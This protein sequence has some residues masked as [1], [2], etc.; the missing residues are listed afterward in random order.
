M[1]RLA[2]VTVRTV[3]HYH[4]LG[5]LAEPERQENGYRS[6]DMRD[7]IRVLRI[8]NLSAAGVP[9]DETAI[10]LDGGGIADDTEKLLE[11]LDQELARKIEYL[12]SQRALIASAR[13]LRTA[14]DLPPTL[15]HIIAL[16]GST[17]ASGLAASTRD[18][19]V[20]LAHLVGVDD[21][22]KVMAFFDRVSDPRILP[23]LLSAS[24]R[25]EELT[26]Y[27][28]DDAITAVVKDLTAVLAALAQSFDP[29]KGALVLDGNALALVDAYQRDMLNDAQ[30]TVLARLG[31]DDDTRANQKK[32]RP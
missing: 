2:G 26:A 19:F 10:I 28:D 12:T 6:Y 25:F 4:Q 13:A 20:L 23:R 1:A 21:R 30:R 31:S 18:Q 29:G 27:S 5:I 32:R 3:R 14:P 16:L 11:T 15:G 8:K 7:L 24:Q 17:D 9:L 22:A